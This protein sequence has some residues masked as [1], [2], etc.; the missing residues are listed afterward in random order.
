MRAMALVGD[1]G[2][3][4]LKLI[5][6]PMPEPRHGEV[7]IRIAAVS[8]NYRDM[9]MV[10]GTYPF[11][12]PLPLVPTSDGVGKVV[13]VGEG[14]T[15]AKVGDRVLGTFHQ[16]WIAGRYEEG[17]PQL[18]GS[19][20]GMLA[21]YVR[22]DQQGIVHAPANLTDEEAAT[23]PCAALTSWFSLVTESHLEAGD[24]VLIQGT[25]G[26]S[27]FGLQFSAIFGARTI[28]TSSSDA[29]LE[30]A[31]SLGATHTINYV[32]TPVWHPEVRAL[33]GGRGVDHVLEV[34]GPDSFLQSLQAIRIGGQ[35]NM[36]GYVGSKQG[37]IN[38]LEILYHRATVRGIPVG[39]RESFEA[40]NRA[41]EANNMR[42]VIDKVFPWTDAGAAIR[43]M[44]EGKH[45]GKIILKFDR[46]GQ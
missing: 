46:A 12:F 23:L 37:A 36:V 18:G 25:G 4:H 27:L 10:L 42:P 20:D 21:E 33:N 16:S 2:L 32:K 31:R 14:V 34:G 6:R 39:S 5:D 22:L 19:A 8:L 40:M 24:T 44:Q 1:F 9:D 15:R 28:V 3:D 17:T 35:I 26:V 11:K 29:K 7:V 13:A 30:R 45:F 38:P 41:I 43:Y